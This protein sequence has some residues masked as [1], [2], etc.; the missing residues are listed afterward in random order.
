[1]TTTTTKE[2]KMLRDNQALEPLYLPNLLLRE[3]TADK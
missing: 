2:S 3:V 1:M